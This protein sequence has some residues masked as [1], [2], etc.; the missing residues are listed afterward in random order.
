LI[1]LPIPPPSPQPIRGNVPLAAAY[2]KLFA[3]RQG[4]ERDFQIDLLPPVLA[5]TLGDRALVE[6]I[7]GR[8]PWMVGFSCYLWNIDRTL[9]IVDRLKERRPELKV[10]LGGP[11]ITPDNAWALDRPGV[12]F[13]VFGEGERAFVELLGKYTCAT[14]GLPSSADNTIGQ[15][16]RRPEVGDAASTAGQAGHRPKV[17][18]GTHRNP[19][20]DRSLS[21]LDAVSSPYIEGIIDADDEQT[22]FLETVRGCRFKCRY[23]YYPK[24][25]SAL[26][27]LSPEQ[28]AANLRYASQ[29]EV[30]EVFLL[31]PTLNQR[32]DFIDFLHLLEQGN[33]ERRFTYSGELRAEGIDAA[34]ARLMRRANFKEVEIG[35]QSIDPQAQKLMGRGADL[36]AL[37]AGAKALMDEGVEV[38]LDL[39]LGL[40]GETVDSFRRGLDYLLRTRPFSQLQVFNLS[41]LPGTSFRRHAAQLGIEYQSRPPYYVLQTPTL[42]VEQMRM[43]MAEAQEAFDVEF[44]AFPPPLLEIGDDRDRPRA[45]CRADLDEASRPRSADTLGATAG[46]SS[47]AGNTV[48]QANRGTRAGETAAPLPPAAERAQAFTLWLRSADFRRRRAIA[49][50]LIS[51]VLADNPHTT[52]QVVLEPVGDLHRLDVD[53]LDALL[54]ACHASSSYLDWYYSLHPTGLLGAKRLIVVAAAERQGQVDRRWMDEVSQ[55]ATLVWQPADSRP[56]RSTLQD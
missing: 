22:M 55:C 54:A 37:E 31:D 33:A 23:C 34:A 45:G 43:L 39:I 24:G 15:V 56:D 13:T 12:D 17:G 3:R 21:S 20:V 25:H 19:L 51:S 42:D 32:P 10:L 35:L 53:T 8:L 50:E 30:A 48:G 29:R 4:L 5:N 49:A 36:K 47:S 16:W 28:I 9:W 27:F 2:L 38:R 1:Q 44:D 7:I 18:R 46:L 41:I 14:A 11:E 26:Q 6:E 52:L 40:P